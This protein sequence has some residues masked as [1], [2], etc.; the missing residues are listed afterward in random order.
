MLLFRTCSG[1]RSS[2]HTVPTRATTAAASLVVTVGASGAYTVAIITDS[3]T[4]ADDPAMCLGA[5]VVLGDG[6]AKVGVLLVHVHSDQHGQNGN[7]RR[8]RDDKAV[9]CLL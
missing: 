7:Q 5:L 9:Q 1:F 4:I 3:V 6:D 2:W 8:T